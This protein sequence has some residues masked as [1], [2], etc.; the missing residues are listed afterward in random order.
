MYTPIMSIDTH[1]NLCSYINNLSSILYH[2]RLP[3]YV[4][5]PMLIPISK[6]IKRKNIPA[7]W[8]QLECWHASAFHGVFVLKP[9]PVNAGYLL[10]H[11]YIWVKSILLALQKLLQA[12]MASSSHSASS[13]R[14]FR[15]SWHQKVM[16]TFACIREKRSLSTATLTLSLLMNTFLVRKKLSNSLIS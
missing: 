8:R 5:S 16:L 6:Q 4:G 7:L 13:W 1:P 9:P 11:I 14:I 2:N 12:N 3:S 10:T 15:S